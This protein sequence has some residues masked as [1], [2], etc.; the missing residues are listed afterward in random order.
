MDD[1]GDNRTSVT[2]AEIAVRAHQ[3]WIEQ[4]KPPDSAD[5]NWL[6]AER[7]LNAATKSRSLLE[8]VTQRAGSV[9]P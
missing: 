2:H 4:G 3:L 1:L 8:K 7:E 5:K 6:E 9:Q